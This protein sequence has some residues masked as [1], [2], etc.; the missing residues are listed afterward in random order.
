MKFNPQN[1]Q[2]N[3]EQL[4][5][6]RTNLA[7]GFFATVIQQSK[8]VLQEN[9]TK[10]PA[11]IA[12]YALGEAYA[13]HAFSGKDYSLSKYYF[14]KLINNFPSSPLAWEARTFV[15]IYETFSFEQKALADLR[16]KAVNARLARVAQV[17]QHFPE[18]IKRN[19]EIIKQSG[20]QPPA[21]AALYNLGLIYAHIDNPAKDFQKSRGFFQQLTEEFP[22]SPFSE[23]SRVWLGIFQ[24]IDK[25]QQIDLEIEQQK[26][27]L[28]R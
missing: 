27:Q 5:E 18:A 22:A 6:Y 20:S 12:L 2:Q 7:F 3:Q 13:H 21:D 8:Q 9:E 26:K 10:A 28:N 4:A 25:M 16:K 23:E 1:F 19:I 24:A 17:N 11:D 15:S 14:D